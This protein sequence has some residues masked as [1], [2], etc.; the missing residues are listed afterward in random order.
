MADGNKNRS[1]R[2]YISQFR[3]SGHWAVSL[4]RDIL[5]VVAVVGGIA[6]AL[7][8]I[9]GAW[10]A[11]VTIESESMVPNMNV[12]DLV[13]V[14]Q[15]DRY[16]DFQTWTEGKGTGYRKF[17]DY[18]DV[19][20]YRPNGVSGSIIP[21]PLIASSPHPII[22]R[23]MMWIEAKDITINISSFYTPHAGYITKGDHN[24]NI[25]QVAVYPDIGLIEPVKEE[26]VIGKCIES[27]RL[28]LV[29]LADEGNVDWSKPGSAILPFSCAIVESLPTEMLLIP[30]PD[31]N[32]GWGVL[33]PDLM[34][35]GNPGWAVTMPGGCW[36]IDFRFPLESVSPDDESHDTPRWRYFIG[37]LLAGGELLQKHI[38]RSP[39]P[40]P[41]SLNP[42]A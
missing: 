7:Y 23:A 19:I 29:H 21:V 38:P 10:P 14:V 25:D 42:D 11:V 17:N 12:G 32:P 40:N 24:K 26:W 20:V 28:Y 5:W 35:D 9:C 22:H 3:T 41:Q 2:D 1:L 27:G 4:A 13:V 6:L 30:F 8:L 34:P 39:T 33:T 37:L 31:G 36:A 15:K 16:G 18:G